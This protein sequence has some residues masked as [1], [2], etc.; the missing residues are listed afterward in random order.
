MRISRGRVLTLRVVNRNAFSVKLDGALRTN[1]RLGPGR[2]RLVLGR[3]RT[4]LGAAKSRR[5]K[6][7]LSRRGAA[8]LTRQGSLYVYLTVVA[9]DA[10]AVPRADEYTFTLLPAKGTR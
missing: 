2:R 4:S 6:L 8:T 9:R 5:V 1:R 10:A 3:L 7:K